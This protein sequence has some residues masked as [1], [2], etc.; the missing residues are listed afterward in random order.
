MIEE[1]KKILA[2][3]KELKSFGIIIGIILLGI[4][5][6]LFINEKEFY[7]IFIFIG[8]AFIGFG[9]IV[10]IVLKPFYFIWMVFSVILGWVMT[11]VI[12]SLIFYFIITP[13]GLVSRIVSKDFLGLKIKNQDSY[14]NHRDR[15]IELNQNYEKQF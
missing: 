3:K 14:W 4:G 8:I 11:R 6:L 7:K 13:I 9:I 10:P 12:L 1:I 5:V 2:N 15:D